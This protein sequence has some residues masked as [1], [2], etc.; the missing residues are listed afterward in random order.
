MNKRDQITRKLIS[1]RKQEEELRKQLATLDYDKRMKDAKKYLGKYYKEIEKYR[2]TQHIHCLYV[3]NINVESV[4]LE[5]INIRYWK[6]GKTH[7][8]IEYYHMFNPEK[9]PDDKF[10]EITKAEYEKHFKIVMKKITEA[11][12]KQI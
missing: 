11:I 12:S 3:Y 6:K 4:D 7:F 10:K 1:V 9:W 2:D 5:S 8:E